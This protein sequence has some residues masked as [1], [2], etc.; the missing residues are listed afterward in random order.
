MLS[1]ELRLLMMNKR[2]KRVKVWRCKIC[3]RSGRCGGVRKMEVWRSKK[4][5]EWRSGGA[6]NIKIE[7]Q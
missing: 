6:N 3:K 4:Q 5:E 2:N 1:G 7:M